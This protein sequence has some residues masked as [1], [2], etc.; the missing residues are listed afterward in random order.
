MKRVRRK[1]ITRKGVNNKRGAVSSKQSDKEKQKNYVITRDKN[2][3]E[4]EK[5][6]QYV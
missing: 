4:K 3:R 6:Q 1:A 5:R 2:A